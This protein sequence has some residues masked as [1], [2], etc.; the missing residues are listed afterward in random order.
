V[1]DGDEVSALPGR[2]QLAPPSDDPPCE[3]PV[4]GEEQAGGAARGACIVIGKVTF[5]HF[6]ELGALR[7]PTFL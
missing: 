6:Y 4:V 3:H 7:G 1:S 5:M 2:L